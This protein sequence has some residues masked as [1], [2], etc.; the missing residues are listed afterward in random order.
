MKTKR[1][2][3]LKILDC[4]ADNGYITN[5]IAMRSLKINNPFE[6]MRELR[7]NINIEDFYVINKT[8]T[9]FKIFYLSKSKA[10]AYMNRNGWKLA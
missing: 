2:H 3:K 10:L 6:R 8:G 4:L 5:G 7:M 9:R 1:T